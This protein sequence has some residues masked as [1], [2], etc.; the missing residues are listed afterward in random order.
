MTMTAPTMTAPMTS[1]P[2]TTG[3]VRRAPR[4]TG[5]ST[6]PSSLTQIPRA[7]LATCPKC[8]SVRLT[9]IAMTLTDGTPVSF[10]SCHSCQYRAWTDNGIALP[11]DRVLAKTQRNRVPGSRG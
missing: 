9:Q 7:A 2:M 8:T 11:I 1:A 6:S 10:T 5:R 3:S 4:T